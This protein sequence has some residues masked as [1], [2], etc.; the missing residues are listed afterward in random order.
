ME[1]KITCKYLHPLLTLPP[2]T[3]FLSTA[4]SGDAI[5]NT[6]ATATKNPGLERGE[7]LVAHVARNT[8][9]TRRQMAVIFAFPG[10]FPS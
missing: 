5:A 8:A 7:V 2:A 3:S 10:P 4:V 6:E 9:R 1:H